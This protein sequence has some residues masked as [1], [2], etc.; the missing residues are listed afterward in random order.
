MRAWAE[1]WNGRI[2][3]ECKPGLFM[4]S[5]R[6][7]RQTAKPLAPSRSDEVIPRVGSSNGAQAT[8]KGR[9]AGGRRSDRR[10]AVLCRNRPSDGARS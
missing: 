3:V 1:P 5:F 2:S 8:P 6:A 9:R 7:K 10:L 4:T